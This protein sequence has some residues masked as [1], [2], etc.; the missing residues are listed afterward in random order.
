MHW[1]YVLDNALSINRLG[2][3]LD[4]T[5]FAGNAYS[6]VVAIGGHHHDR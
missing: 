4:S 6:L 5:E 1:H 2:N 3:E